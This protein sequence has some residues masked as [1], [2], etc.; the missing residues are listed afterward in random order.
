ML[1]MFL[2]LNHFLARSFTRST[3]AKSSSRDARRPAPRVQK[4][5]ADLRSPFRSLVD[6]SARFAVRPRYPPAQ[7]TALAA[8]TGWPTFCA[9]GWAWPAISGQRQLLRLAGWWGYGRERHPLPP[10]LNGRTSPVM[11]RIDQLVMRQVNF[12]DPAQPGRC[13]KRI[14]ALRSK[15]RIRG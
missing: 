1:R 7:Y 2:W 15:L 8:I 11:Q 6:R 10:Y 9:A 14:N 4:I 5:L 12:I 13:Q 3:R